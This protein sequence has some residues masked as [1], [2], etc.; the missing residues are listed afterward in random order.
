MIS[1]SV[2]LVVTAATV[3]RIRANPRR[4]TASREARKFRAN[5]SAKFLR[6]RANPRTGKASREAL[7]LRLE[8]NTGK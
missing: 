7:F 1:R 4:E 2:S 5:P 3:L 6:F 8:K